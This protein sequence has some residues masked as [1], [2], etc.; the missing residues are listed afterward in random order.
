MSANPDKLQEIIKRF[1]NHEVVVFGDYYLDQYISGTILGVS[2]E[3]P[4]LRIV[5]NAV[6]QVPGAA[7]N[8]AANFASL[9]AKVH[10]FGIIGSD[11]EG[12][13][14]INKLHGFRVDTSHLLP[15][16]ARQTG[17]F[18]RIA[19]ENDDGSLHHHIRLDREYVQPPSPKLLK[20]LLDGIQQ[21]GAHANCIYLADYDESHGQNGVLSQEVVKDI[22]G[23][24]RRTGTV[25]AGSSRKKSRIFQNIDLV[26]CN[27]KEAMLLLP[28][29]PDALESLGKAALAG[30][31]CRSLCITCGSKGALFVA[32]DEISAAPVY[33]RNVADPCGGGDAFASAF[34]LSRVSGADIREALEIASHAAGLAVTKKGTAPISDSELLFELQYGISGGPKLKSADDLQKSLEGLRQHKRIVFTNGYFDLFHSG[35]VHLLQEAKKCGDL[36]IV[37]INSDRSTRENKGEGRPVLSARDR[38]QILLA[39]GFVDFVTIFDEL[40][41]INCIRKIR[42]HLVI[43]GG[44]YKKDEVIGKDIVESYGGEVRVI[45][46]NG[47][48]RTLN[49]IN[50]IK[51]ASDG[52]R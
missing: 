15:D 37:A 35:H 30:I 19:S 22:R 34:A 16:P 25:L 28:Q 24:F 17:T 32:D 21:I 44:N 39:L 52:M 43:K 31:G 26:F 14:L 9:G 20:Q 18:T 40:T 50:M 7:G 47:E 49:L 13:D 10:A 48:I 11:R 38:I 41:P 12:A 29:P 6:E 5:E 1:A 4:V 3:M 8:V 33:K 42:P 36:L 23:S 51:D 46:Y 2:P 45:P 27:Q